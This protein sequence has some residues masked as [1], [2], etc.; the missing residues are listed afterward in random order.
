MKMDRGLASLSGR[1]MPMPSIVSRGLDLKH[2]R[3]ARRQQEIAVDLAQ[4]WMDLDV[5][6]LVGHIETL[7]PKPGYVIA[8]T[9]DA[10][11]VIGPGFPFAPVARV[12]GFTI[13]RR[14]N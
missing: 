6:A 13:M 4:A 2:F 14:G 8:P 3:F 1:A 5:P 11:R 9:W 12:R 7:N 10:E